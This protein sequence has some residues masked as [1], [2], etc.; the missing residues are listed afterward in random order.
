MS[1]D[2]TEMF[3]VLQLGVVE[4]AWFLDRSADAHTT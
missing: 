2:V 1:A 3:H 4:A